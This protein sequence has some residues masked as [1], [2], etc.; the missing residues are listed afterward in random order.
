[1]TSNLQSHTA[2][3]WLPTVSWKAEA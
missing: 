2:E 1:M 3:C